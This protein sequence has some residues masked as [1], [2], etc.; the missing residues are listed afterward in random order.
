MTNFLLIIF[1]FRFL[2]KTKKK[3]SE[4]KVRGRV[5]NHCFIAKQQKHKQIQWSVFH[6][7]WKLRAKT[8]RSSRLSKYNQLESLF[9]RIKELELKIREW[10]SKTTKTYLFLLVSIIIRWSLLRVRMDWL[11]NLEWK[12]HIPIPLGNILLT[13]YQLVF[14]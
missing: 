6:L 11:L 10:S 1:L 12:L 14:L 9:R 5:E 8:L 7:H 2:E 13:T 4:S 3:P